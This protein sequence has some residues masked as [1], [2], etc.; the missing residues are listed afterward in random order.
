LKLKIKTPLESINKAYL[1]Q[2]IP[3]SDRIL[4]KDEL[5]RVIENINE[6]QDEEYHKNLI[7]NFLKKVFYK[8]DYHIN[9][10]KRLDL[11][12]RSGKDKNDPVNVILEFKK[13]SSREMISYDKPN[14][15]SFHQ[16]V[17]YYLEERISNNNAKVKNLIITNLDEWYIFDEIWFSKYINGNS[18]FR[19]DYEEF[20]VNKGK[21]TK[22]FYKDIAEPFLE[23]LDEEIPCTYFSLK[24][25]L[26][27]SEQEIT[28]LYRLLSPEHLLKKPFSNDSNELN[29][30]FYDEL[31]WILGL[32]EST[33]KSMNTIY[34]F[35]K[36]E[37]QEASLLES[38]ILKIQY[39]NKFKNLTNKKDYGASEDDQAFS[40]ALE[41]CITWLNRILFLKLLEGQI[42]NYHK[43]IAPN[44]SFLNSEKLQSFSELNELFF[45]VLAVRVNERATY[46]FEKYQ[47]IPYLNSSLFDKSY[48][49]ENILSI[50]E[51]TNHN[52]LNIFQS[53][54]LTNNLGKKIT[55]KKNTLEYLLNFLNSFDFS[56]ESNLD[57][58]E[59][60]K[61]II[62]ASVL[63]LIFEK[64]NGYRD[65]S[66][67]TPGFITMHMCKESI[68]SVV[69]KKFNAIK[70]WNC[71]DFKAL[72]DKIDGRN[73]DERKEAN[74]II[75]NIKICDPAVGSGHFL[76]S[77]LNE[78]ISIKSEL[79][80]LTFKD[81]NRIKGYNIKVENDRLAIINIE[82][83]EPFIY[84]LNQ[85]NK[86]I[87]ELQEIQE[88]IFHE[89][90]TIIENCLFGVDLNPKSVMICCL[91][92][93]I[94]LLKNSYYTKESKYKELETL[95][96]IDINIKS[97][98]SL[99]SIFDIKDKEESLDKKQIAEKRKIINQY[100]DLVNKYK[101]TL[102][103]K[104]ELKNQIKAI[105]ESFVPFAKPTKKIHDE[106]F[107]LK[108]DS[109]LDYLIH[110]SDTIEKVKQDSKRL[111]ELENLVGE[112]FKTFYS[113]AL[114]W[115]FEFPEVLTDNG[116]YIGFDII[117]GNPPYIGE[118][119]NS[120]LFSSYKILDKWKTILTKRTNIYYAFLIQSLSLLQK[121]GNICLIIP[122]EL[123]TSD[124]AKHVR[125]S[126]IASSSIVSIYDFNKNQVFKGVGTN[127]MI[128]S[129]TDEV[130]KDCHYRISENTSQEIKNIFDL[131][132]KENSI[133]KEYLVSNEYWRLS[134]PFSENKKNTTVKL[135]HYG[136][137]T[138]QGIITGAN[139]AKGKLFN[140]IINKYPEY[141]KSE[142][143]GIFVLENHTDIKFEDST[144]YINNS[145]DNKNPIW[146]KLNKIEKDFIKP[147]CAGKDINKY[148][149]NEIS[150]YVIW[151]NK[152]NFSKDVFKKIPNIQEH[153]DN[154]KIFLIN[155]NAKKFITLEL[156]EKTINKEN[157]YNGD[158]DTQ[159]T[160]GKG[161]YYVLQ[162]YAY[163]LNF[164]D[165]KIFWQSRG[166]TIFYF[167][168]TAT[169]GLSS[170]NF[171]YFKNSFPEKYKS[172]NQKDIMIFISAILNSNIYQKY[173]KGNNNT[174][175]KIKNIDVIKLD[176]EDK[177][178]MKYYKS[179]VDK[180]IKMT[181]ISNS[182][183]KLIAEDDKLYNLENEINV[184]ISQLYEHK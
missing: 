119:D 60:H 130:V 121:D 135:E 47:G 9:I 13:H 68:R 171:L 93:W 157:L 20:K 141:K 164:E 155:R 125:K 82:T 92:L 170:I 58:D 100:K 78:I 95:P 132:Y 49:E 10:N 115:R 14:V 86:P 18:Q 54:V 178:H 67:Y 21:G 74:L 32:Q 76:V 94:E 120:S 83:D 106:F 65:G 165:K 134:E 174:G 4:F 181:S 63:G 77:A 131:P 51:L 56:S 182:K 110:S 28:E 172:L 104:Q 144:I 150:T 80:I 139:A 98:N 101:N 96:N 137:T 29:K 156:F 151:L 57:S 160:L 12:I 50:S 44:F 158:G 70:N 103:D 8:E 81:G 166:E 35:A 30:E 79:D 46:I 64:I 69:I 142:G 89:K 7:S 138:Q 41:L 27:Y 176:V 180:Y 102:I 36:T 16:L 173:Y 169:Y 108:E 90:R 37:R 53:T 62:N 25:N 161:N 99:I 105:K 122:N 179:I 40:I 48:L 184:L 123:L 43:K 91:R 71:K 118:K 148:Y 175:T 85:N 59:S 33:S 31:L 149:L 159:G 75:N 117:I 177:E 45:D 128:L 167:N 84:T 97:G 87:E 42:K 72:K 152:E 1:K 39:S 147:L 15:K 129:Y 146:R 66:F 145:L 133:S 52:T 88:A 153:L 183:K 73:E 19:R 116:D 107:R 162:K 140:K 61:E 22:D 55:G 2:T 5:N 38:V 163:G 127:A 23:R 154:F 124:Y 6:N 24:R 17:Y 112:E 136:L 11:V 114:E 111:T 3:K 26:K 126:I 143:L 109:K 168:D 34:R 113:N